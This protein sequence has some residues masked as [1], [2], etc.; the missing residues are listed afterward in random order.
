MS[1]IGRITFGPPRSGGLAKEHGEPFIPQPANKRITEAVSAEHES[2]TRIANNYLDQLAWLEQAA[3]E[4][5]K[6][7]PQFGWMKAQRELT[8]ALLMHARSLI[9]IAQTAKEYTDATRPADGCTCRRCRDTER[10]RA[11]LKALEDKRE[12]KASKYDH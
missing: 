1:D 10:L 8:T 4:C 3:R 7:A 5:S 9:E 2:R 6:D 12:S 11:A